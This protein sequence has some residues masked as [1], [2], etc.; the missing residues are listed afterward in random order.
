[1]LLFN[2]LKQLLMHFW[3]ASITANSPRLRSSQA[4]CY[5]SGPCQ[6]F[7]DDD[8]IIQ[9]TTQ[10]IPNLR[11]NGPSSEYSD[12]SFC[13]ARKEQAAFLYV[14]SRMWS[15]Q[16]SLNSATCWVLKPKP[17]TAHSGWSVWIYTHTQMQ[18]PWMSSKAWH[19]DYKMLSENAVSFGCISYLWY[20]VTPFHARKTH[21]P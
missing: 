6:Y 18:S 8:S 17:L 14:I 13:S 16:V 2:A 12:H 1:M 7:V 9:I 4:D 3:V 19:G 20:L 11:A 5:F 10:Q 21:F 15:N